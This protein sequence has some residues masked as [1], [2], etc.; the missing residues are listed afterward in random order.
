MATIG[1]LLT[2]KKKIADTKV[3]ATVSPTKTEE[4]ESTSK[5]RAPGIPVFDCEYYVMSTGLREIFFPGNKLNCYDAFSHWLQHGNKTHPKA[6]LPPLGFYPEF[7]C[8]EYLNRYPELKPL[9][10]MR[11]NIHYDC[12]NLKLWFE[13]TGKERK[14]VAI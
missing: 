8:L 7:D 3:E 1:Y 4:V 12:T 14:H 9:F 11:D 2:K 6:N 13:Y 5:A 10:L